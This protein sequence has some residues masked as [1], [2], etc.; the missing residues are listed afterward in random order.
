MDRNQPSIF[1]MILADYTSY[2][3]AILTAILW[4]IFIVDRIFPTYS[5]LFSFLV[6]VV[7]VASA[8]LL[9]VRYRRVMALFE[10]CLETPGVIEEVVSF[11][12]R[13][14]VIYEFTFRGERFAIERSFLRSKLIEN[15]APGKQITVLVDSDNLQQSIIKDIYTQ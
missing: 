12:G 7:S 6:L 11:R 15:L 1:R 10:T 13:V 8:A 5:V 14:S 9:L 2:Q 4:L 3:A